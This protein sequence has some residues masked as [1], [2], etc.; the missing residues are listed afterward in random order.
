MD[1]KRILVIGGTGFIGNHIISSS[2]QKGYQPCSFSLGNR[3]TSL[4]GVEYLYGDLLNKNEIRKLFS[5]N[6]FEYIVDCGGYINH[7]NFSS[8]GENIIQEHLNSLYSIVEGLDRKVLRK[9]LYLGSSDE[10]GNNPAPQNEEMKERPISPYSYAK[11]AGS[12]FL[13]MMFRSEKLP[14]SIAR[15]FLTYGPGQDDKRFIPQIIK[16]CLKDQEFPTSFGEQFRDFCYVD[17]SIDGIFKILE[18]EES[19]GEIFNIASGQNITIRAMIEKLVKYIGKGRPKFG[20]VAYRTGENM[21]LF[22]DISKAKK[23]L[24]WEPK[25]SLDDGLQKTIEYYKN[26]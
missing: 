14:V 4:N 18:N 13:Q 26:V 19:N 2:L 16:G 20:E 15:L 9:F 12:H 11:A 24:N 6:S 21:E 17:D 10:Y 7:I 3:K 25:V 8:G 5:E 23:V 22:A 1:K